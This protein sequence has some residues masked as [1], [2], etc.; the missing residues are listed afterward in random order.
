MLAGA[1][2]RMPAAELEE[3][4]ENRRGRLSARDRMA[5][6]AL[7]R[8]VAGHGRSVTCDGTCIPLR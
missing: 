3:T 7:L 1:A 6:E 5:R 4:A 8:R 2:T